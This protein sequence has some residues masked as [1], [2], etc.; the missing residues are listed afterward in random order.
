MKLIYLKWKDACFDTE[1]KQPKNLDLITLESI[2]FFIK[3]NEEMVVMAQDITGENYCRY[4]K[5][6]PKVNILER[7]DINIEGKDISQ[8]ISLQEKST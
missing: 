6:I 2:G 3:E 1:D 5:A 4:S 7:R 8:G